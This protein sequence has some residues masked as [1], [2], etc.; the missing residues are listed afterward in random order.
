MN[1][2][3]SFGPAIVMGEWTMHW[4]RLEN[5]LS[6]IKMVLHLINLLYF[7]LNKLQSSD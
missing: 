5:D 4:V 3:R 6:I 1:T 7:E 2:A